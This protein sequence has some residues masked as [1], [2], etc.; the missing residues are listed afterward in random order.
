[1]TSTITKCDNCGIEKKESNNWYT[2]VVNDNI[3]SLT[4]NSLTNKNHWDRELG[5]VLDTCGEECATKLIWENLNK[6]EDPY[7]EVGMN[8]K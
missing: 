3:I 6:P 1:M 2:I 7:R 8:N 4:N 5:K